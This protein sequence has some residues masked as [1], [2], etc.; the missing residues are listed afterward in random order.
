MFIASANMLAV[1]TGNATEL[2][3]AI[4][5]VVHLC[6]MITPLALT[7]QETMDLFGLVNLQLHQLMQQLSLQLKYN[8]VFPKVRLLA[9][10]AVS[11]HMQKPLQRA[12]PLHCT[13]LAWPA[14][15][16]S[17]ACTSRLHVTA[18][19]A[20]LVCRQSTRQMHRSCL[21]CWPPSC[22]QKWRRSTSICRPDMQQTPA[23]SI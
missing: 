15:H 5:S 23:T 19:S 6:K 9:A 3:A 7:R 13:N 10:T 18:R 14:A 11:A 2:Q 12:W 16:A 21:F 22:C 20:S 4:A 17:N 8:T 1:S